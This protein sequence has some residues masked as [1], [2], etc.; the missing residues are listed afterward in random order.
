MSD[1]YKIPQD[2]IRRVTFTN[3]T[4]YSAA[5]PSSAG[6]DFE[7]TLG[8]DSP[9]GGTYGEV[10]LSWRRFASDRRETW[11]LEAFGDGLP[12]MLAAGLLDLLAGNGNAD[13]AEMKVLLAA[14]GWQDRTER[15]RPG[16]P[17]PASW[18][19]DLVKRHVPA[20]QQAPLLAAVD[21][22]AE[23]SPAL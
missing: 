14:A 8:L 9:A 3:E 4:W 19:R 18:L 23:D 6:S 21:S 2:A 22:I 10:T 15:K 1:G 13:A 5:V 16:A 7:W 17:E 20:E 12:Q 11:R